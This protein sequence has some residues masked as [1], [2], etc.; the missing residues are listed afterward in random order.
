MPPCIA[1]TC[2]L[3]RKARRLRLVALMMRTPGKSM[4][5]AR[6]QPAGVAAGEVTIVGPKARAGDEKLPRPMRSAAHV[7]VLGQFSSTEKALG[8]HLRLVTVRLVA[9]QP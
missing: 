8:R 7:S 1:T 9:V 5:K 4:V 6:V 2:T 3:T